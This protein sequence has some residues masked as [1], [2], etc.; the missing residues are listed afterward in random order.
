MNRN[1]LTIIVSSLLLAACDPQGQPAAQSAGAEKDNAAPAK[2]DAAPTTAAAPGAVPAGDAAPAA[3]GSL[4]SCL[5]TCV[6]DGK[7]SAT[8]RATCRMQCEN[9][10]GYRP[11][12]ADPAAGA[13]PDPVGDAV[14]CLGRCYSAEGATDSC[15]AGCK[16][17]AAAAPVGPSAAVLDTLSTCIGTCH[18]DKKSIPTNRATC[19]LNCA[20]EARIAG[21]AQAPR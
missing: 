14:S 3:E 6:D 1:L 16:A 12:V 17:T 15:T 7:A 10:H 18:A 20:Q 19:E 11:P 8:D 13:Q 21:P 9:R 5:Q 4:S 2:Q